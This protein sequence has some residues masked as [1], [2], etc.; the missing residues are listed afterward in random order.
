MISDYKWKSLIAQVAALFMVGVLTIGIFT[1]LSQ[2]QVA[3]STVT[4]QT[5]S[6][7]ANI[8]KETMLS[9]QEYPAYQ[10]LV[11]YWYE[12]PDELDIE[13]DVVYD[14]GTRTEEKYNHFREH[15][16]DLV[17]KYLSNEEAE[18]LSAEDQK[19]FAEI[20]YSWLITRVNQ[21]KQTYHVDYLFC[22]LT[23]PPYDRQFFL[24]SAAEPG[25]VRGTNYEE[26]Y[27]LGVISTVAESQQTAMQHACEN[28]SH[29]ADAGSYVDYYTFVENVAGH[30]VLI[31]MTYNLSGIRRDI[32]RQTWRGTSIA[33]FLQVCLSLLCLAGIY[34]LVLSPLREVQQNIREYMHTKDGEKVRKTLSVAVH[35]KNEI[36][37]LSQDVI[38]LTQEIDDHV[39]RIESI[40]AERERIGA[41]LA[42]AARIQANT[43][44]NVFPPFPDRHEFD[45]Y[46][47]MNPAKEVGGDFYDYFLIDDDHLALLIADV[48]GKGVPAA[49][50]MMVSMIIIQNVAENHKSPADILGHVNELICQKNPEEMFVSVWLGI[51]EISTGRMTAANAGHEYPI[52]KDP[53]GPFRLIKDR[54]GF[55]I[56]AMEGVKYTDY[57]LQLAPGSRLFLYTDGLAEATD[58]DGRMFGT[59]RAVAVLN[60]EIDSEPE[61][62]LANMQRAVDVF[63]RDAEQFDD[64]TMLCLA[65]HGADAGKD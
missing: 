19:L 21:I 34:L 5:E 49:L 61:T 23:E 31:G 50:F 38:D 65:Y 15:H 25:S 64:L 30:D 1:Y 60:T 6:M 54:H 39:Q 3:D 33:M 62:I 56:G 43:L 24:F 42:L 51:L 8:A 48:S 45:I 37:E 26:V 35:A 55:V 44:P 18:A 59:D 22:V 13:Y 40:T 16:P 2:K 63:V 41:E 46:A 11:R 47:A 36:G 10:W 4:Q 32:E 14:V 57:E 12:H 27:P 58:A 52:L 29:L 28:E 7:A 20:I 17:M 53:D 9:L